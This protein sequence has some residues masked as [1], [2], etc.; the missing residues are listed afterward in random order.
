MHAGV[1]AS[2]FR[3]RCCGSTS[4]LMTAP[5][6]TRIWLA[7]AV[8][9][10]S[11]LTFWLALLFSCFCDTGLPQE[12]A[13]LLKFGLGQYATAFARWDPSLLPRGVLSLLELGLPAF[14]DYVSPALTSTPRTR[15]YLIEGMRVDVGGLRIP[16][17]AR[18]GIV[19]G[20][21]HTV[22]PMHGMRIGEASNPDPGGVG[23]E[24]GGVYYGRFANEHQAGIFIKRIGTK[25]YLLRRSPRAVVCAESP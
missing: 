7:R 18:G 22:N 6:P 16:F 24:V 5:E 25:R 3:H 19:Y 13:A 20:F 11:G 10:W 4:P 12:P 15:S 9:W 14:P 17:R 23:M 21:A 2:K 1:F 8:M